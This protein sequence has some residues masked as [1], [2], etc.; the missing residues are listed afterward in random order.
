MSDAAWLIWGAPAVAFVFAAVGFTIVWLGSRDFD[1]RYGRRPRYSARGPQRSTR[2]HP[3]GI[4]RSWG[5]KRD[6]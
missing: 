1:R 4:S 3:C 5:T 2:A 6:L